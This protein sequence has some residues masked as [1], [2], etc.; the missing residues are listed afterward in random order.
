MK[1]HVQI[2]HEALKVDEEFAGANAE[3]VVHAIKGRVARDLPFAM[4]LFVGGMSDLAFAQEIVRRYNSAEKHNVRIPGSCDEFLTLA[5]S[6]GFATI[7][8]A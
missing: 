6:N 2:K 5:Q 1:V 8:E 7:T 3:A 4:R